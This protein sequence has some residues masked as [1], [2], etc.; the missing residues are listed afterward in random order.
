MTYK[1]GWPTKITGISFPGKPKILT[2]ELQSGPGST[3]NNWSFNAEPFDFFAPFPVG[4]TGTGGPPGF[5]VIIPP[6]PGAPVFSLPT[7]I[8]GTTDDTIGPPELV[9]PMS[10]DMVNRLLL[11]EEPV[12]PFINGN[13]TQGGATLLIDL[14]NAANVLGLGPKDSFQCVINTQSHGTSTPPGP[15][16]FIYYMYFTGQGGDPLCQ[17]NATGDVNT[18]SFLDLTGQLP[19]GVDPTQPEQV[20]Q[21]GLSEPGAGG[22]MGFFNTTQIPVNLWPT[23]FGYPWATGCS[24]S[25]QAAQEVLDWATANAEG[26]PGYVAFFQWAVA[27]VPPQYS[28]SWPW[29]M[30]V[31]TWRRNRDFAM[32][33]DGNLFPADIA[34]S[35]Q[36]QDINSGGGNPAASQITI[37][38]NL[39]DLSFTLRQVFS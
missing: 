38:V 7:F 3:Q 34:G 24:T 16:T 20:A 37:T 14:D 18:Q 33:G 26:L 22:S 2:I 9:N 35:V 5:S 12:P 21:W 10:Q 29:A 11:W 1:F 27:P 19:P 23:Q 32:A 6:T 15:P 36:L 13:Q 8:A 28:V 25:A 31:N 30:R 39:A 4:P 17:F